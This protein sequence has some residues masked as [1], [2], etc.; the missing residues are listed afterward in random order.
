MGR[1]RDLANIL[2]SSGSVALD[3]E[4]AL[5][6]INTTTFSGVTSVSIDNIFSSTYNN[7]KVLASFESFSG[8][9]NVFNMRLRTSG[10]DNTTSNYRY[11]GNDWYTNWNPWYDSLYGTDHF[12]V[13]RYS[14]AGG[15]HMS[16]DFF[17]PFATKYTTWVSMSNQ[18]GTDPGINSG[19]G[20]FLATTSFDGFKFYPQISQNMSG[21]IR[22]YGYKN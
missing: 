15:I 22:V 12:M 11:S 20:G 3:S 5:V 2:S 18:V 6:L 19:G 21:T 1:A 14:R 13:H 8:T 17:N 10:S 7:Y 16:M 9:D 4:L